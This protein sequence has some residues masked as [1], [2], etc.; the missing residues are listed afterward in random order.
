MN[1]L[2]HD[3]QPRVIDNFLT[4]GATVDTLKITVKIH[5][6]AM[7]VRCG[8]ASADQS[9]QRMA[10]TTHIDSLQ[11]A[12]KKKIEQ[13]EAL[14]ETLQVVLLSADF[15]SVEPDS[16]R[17]AIGDAIDDTMARTA[18]RLINLGCQALWDEWWH[19]WLDW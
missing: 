11:R 14:G 13:T 12:V 3:S 18:G 4:Y 10:Y 7:M 2:L 17:D 9:D 6:V 5:V 8:A 15:N 1:I 19:D 16:P